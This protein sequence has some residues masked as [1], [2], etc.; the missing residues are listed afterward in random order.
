METKAGKNVAKKL[1]SLK[2]YGYFVVLDTLGIN[3]DAIGRFTIPSL[4]VTK[5]RG[6]VYFIG[7][8][9]IELSEKDFEEVTFTY[10]KKKLELR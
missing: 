1:N 4:R 3:Y 5:D 9:K 7:D 10:V 6:E 2:N 8:D